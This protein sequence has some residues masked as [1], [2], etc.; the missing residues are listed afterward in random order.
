MVV[1]ERLVDDPGNGLFADS[2]ANED[3]H[4]IKKS[5]GVFLKI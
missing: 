2:E 5:F 1:V 4:V 3:G